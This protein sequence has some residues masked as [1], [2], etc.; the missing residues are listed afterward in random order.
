MI[1]TLTLN[2]AID[3][4][5]QTENYEEKV[6]NRT[7]FSEAT[8]NGK[9][10]NVS[11]I[12]KKLDVDNTALGVG[13]GFTNKYIE[14]VLT[15]TGIANDFVHVDGMTRI[16]VFTQVTATGK[17]YKLV[18]PGP[19]VSD[20]K[21]QELLQKLEALTSEDVLVISGSFAKGIEPSI[22]TTIAKLA[23]AKGFKLVIDTSYKA[24][25]DTLAYHP[26]LLKPNDEELQTW[27]DLDHVPNR[28]ECIDCGKQLIA[29]GAQKVLIS[30]GADGAVLVT[31]ERVIHGT[32]PHGEVVN[33]TCAGDT[34]LGTFIAMQLEG[35]SYA[36]SLTQAIA[37]GSSTAFT[38]GLTDFSDVAQ[39]AEDIILTSHD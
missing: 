19:V 7:E 18:N 1:Y 13:G 6:V 36:E 8:A 5:V 38:S 14:D 17:E 16:N 30:L 10:I 22:L 11:F 12:L 34:M 21:Q 25:L 29:R 32:A 27:F 9:G 35:K 28:E 3:L 26:A 15:E 33:T 4:F 23:E 37:A 2:P 20:A 31:T 24:V 39:L